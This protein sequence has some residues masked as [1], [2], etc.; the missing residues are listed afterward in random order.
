M[1]TANGTHFTTPSASGSAVPLIKEAIA[2]RELFRAHAFEP[3][4]A[5]ADIDHRTTKPK[6]PWANGGG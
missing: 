6:H 1:L 2:N 5:K 4:C 3:A